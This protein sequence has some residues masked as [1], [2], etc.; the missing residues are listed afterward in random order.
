M[1]LKFII[2]YFDLQNV[3]GFSII[4]IDFSQYKFKPAG[5][6]IYTQREIDKINESKKRIC[7]LLKSIAIVFLLFSAFQSKFDYSLLDIKT[8]NIYL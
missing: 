2:L 3:L 6:G 5:S 8:I 4:K 1:I 7:I